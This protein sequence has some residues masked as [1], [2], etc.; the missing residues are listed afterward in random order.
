MK[1]KGA[2]GKRS[3]KKEMDE[4][5]SRQRGSDHRTFMDQWTCLLSH[6]RGRNSRQKEKCSLS[7]RLFKGTSC[8]YTI[9]WHDVFIAAFWN[10]LD[11]FYYIYDQHFCWEGDEFVILCCQPVEG[12][13]LRSTYCYELVE[14]LIS[15]MDWVFWCAVSSCHVSLVVYGS[16][17]CRVRNPI[18]D[19][20][21]EPVVDSFRE[22]T[23]SP[24]QHP[25]VQYRDTTV[26]DFQQH[27]ER[28]VLYC[29]DSRGI[30]I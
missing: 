26:R 17:E 6:Y 4:K 14:I 21:Q 16:S 15:V 10:E 3:K 12:W 11:V 18:H 7:G 22:L 24:V 20:I 27:W 29:S 19:S 30:I 25:S 23:S 5:E 28:R 8:N 9:T 2:A 1:R 13:E